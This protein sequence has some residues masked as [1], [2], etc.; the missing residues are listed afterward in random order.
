[1]VLPVTFFVYGV[2]TMSNGAN[3][4]FYDLFAECLFACTTT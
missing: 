3:I 2:D 4:V 1:M